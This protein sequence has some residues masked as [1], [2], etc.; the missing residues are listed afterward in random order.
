MQV[1]TFRDQLLLKL[2]EKVTPQ[3]EKAIILFLS[4]ENNI[5]VA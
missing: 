2:K 4:V 5:P 1:E 3:N